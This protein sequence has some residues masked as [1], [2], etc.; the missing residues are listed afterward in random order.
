MK[1][2]LTKLCGGMLTVALA[3]A[4]S[5]SAWAATGPHDAGWKARGMHDYQSRRTV[6]YYSAPATTAPAGR[7]AFSYEPTPTPTAPATAAAP[8]PQAN[9]GYRSYTYEPAPVRTRVWRSSRDSNHF[10]G[11]YSSKATLYNH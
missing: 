4:L 1:T 9:S 5:S 11:N 10:S 7:Q 3:M 6:R 8:A 2:T